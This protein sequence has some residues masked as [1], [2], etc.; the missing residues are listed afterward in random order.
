MAKI[1]RLELKP[2]VTPV[3]SLVLL[4]L[5]AFF[6]GKAIFA[7]IQKL[8]SKLDETQKTLEV[9]KS[10]T[11][12]IETFQPQAKDLSNAASLALPENN[13]SLSLLSQLK[14][15][16]AERSLIINKLKIGTVQEEDGIAKVVLNFEVEGDLGQIISFTQEISNLS[17]INRVEKIKLSSQGVIARANL[18]VD[19]FWAS[20]PKTIP[21]ITKAKS[22]FSAAEQE[23]LVELLKLKSPQFVDL[24]EAS[25]PIPRPDP[26]IF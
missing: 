5:V 22:G 16:A 12:L 15:E 4:L 20:F 13:S 10:N 17:P 2:L 14:T 3:F 26:F 11:D 8:N 19:S 9:L 23:L 21:D 18:T 7:N 6:A 25:N 24:S 1:S